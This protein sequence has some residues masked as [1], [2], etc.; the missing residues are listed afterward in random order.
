MRHSIRNWAVLA[1]FAASFHAYG[2]RLVVDTGSFFDGI[3]G[4]YLIETVAGQ[5]PHGENVLADV[6]NDASQREGFIGMPYCPDSGDTCD[7]G[8]LFFPHADTLVIQ[9]ML[10]DGSIQTVIE[11]DEGGITKIYH[12]VDSAGK[13][14]FT[15]F[16]YKGGTL[17]HELK[18]PASVTQ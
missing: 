10:D 15:N 14:T 5:P 7:P 12:W 17:V 11:V 16:Q 6:D 3:K 13:I 9:N 18:K 2:M 8:Y 1:C 4:Q